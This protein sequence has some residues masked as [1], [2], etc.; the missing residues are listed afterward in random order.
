MCITVQINPVNLL[1]LQGYITY[2][3]IHIIHTYAHCHHCMEILPCY[4]IMTYIH[5][6]NCTYVCLPLR[7]I[8][9]WW[10][11]RYEDYMRHWDDE[12]ANN[13]IMCPL[14][15]PYKKNYYPSWLCYFALLGKS[16]NF[17]WM[18]ICRTPTRKI[19]AVSPTINHD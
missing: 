8:S 1:S 16:E 9:L 14:L 5:W 3:P 2:T 19:F 18:E 17:A 13:K 11:Q 4:E 6:R 10:S 7:I 12:M 15:S